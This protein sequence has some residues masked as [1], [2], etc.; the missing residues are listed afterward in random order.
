[1][2]YYHT[3]NYTDTN[4]TGEANG[5]SSTPAQLSSQPVEESDDTTEPVPRRLPR[6]ETKENYGIMGANFTPLELMA[7]YTAAAMHD[8]QHPGKNN[9]FLVDTE[10][11]LVSKV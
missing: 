1:M 9:K 7:F 2:N 10:H 6:F 3:Y 4:A 11:S 5:D 8:Y